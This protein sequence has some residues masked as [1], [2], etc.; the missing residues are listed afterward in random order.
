MHLGS[1][2]L[3]AGMDPLK[4]EERTPALLT[5]YLLENEVFQFPNTGNQ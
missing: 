3:G 4:A 5:E 1:C 2:F